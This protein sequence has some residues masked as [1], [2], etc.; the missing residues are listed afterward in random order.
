[1]SDLI[2]NPFKDEFGKWMKEHVEN[3]E[4]IMII[5][6]RRNNKTLITDIL[7]AKEVKEESNANRH[8]SMDQGE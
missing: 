5:G 1:M 6:G 4:S 2:E 8:G 7:N 3:G